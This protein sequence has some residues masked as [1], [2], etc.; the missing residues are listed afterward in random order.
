MA[1]SALSRYLA[2]DAGCETQLTSWVEAMQRVPTSLVASLNGH[3]S[4]EFNQ[5]FL[6][7][8]VGAVSPNVFALAF[9]RERVVTVEVQAA[10]A[11]N[12]TVLVA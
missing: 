2:D 1:S 11:L 7:V 12:G 9:C 6:F 5:S 4:P 10:Q 3:L 8:R